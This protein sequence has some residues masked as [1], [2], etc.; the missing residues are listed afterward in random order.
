MYGTDLLKDG[1]EKAVGRTASAAEVFAIH[2]ARGP[3]R[4]PRTFQASTGS[5]HFI[6]GKALSDLQ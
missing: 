1:K 6:K 3:A 4:S 2:T 5:V